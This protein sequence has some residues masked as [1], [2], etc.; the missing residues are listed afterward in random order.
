MVISPLLC[1]STLLDGFVT[2]SMLAFKMTTG[3]TGTLACM[4]LLSTGTARI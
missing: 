1:S 4:P 2:F 3:V